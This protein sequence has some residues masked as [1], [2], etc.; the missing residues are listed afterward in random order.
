MQEIITL[1][2]GIENCNT[3]YEYK[4]NEDYII[5]LCAQWRNEE[6]RVTGLFWG[7]SKKF[8]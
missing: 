3:H 1:H 2:C 4:N 5:A 8:G 7:L 6:S